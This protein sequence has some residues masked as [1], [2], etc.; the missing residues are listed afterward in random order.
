[1]C[2]ASAPQLRQEGGERGPA[3]AAV[4]GYTAITCGLQYL[5]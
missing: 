5:T 3:V 1:M 2:V 4:G